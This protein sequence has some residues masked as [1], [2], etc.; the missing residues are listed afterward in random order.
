MPTKTSPDNAHALKTKTVCPHGRAMVRSP[1]RNV[2][3]AWSFSISDAIGR[4]AFAI[5]G[6]SHAVPGMRHPTMYCRPIM[7]MMPP[8]RKQV[9]QGI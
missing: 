5:S 4:L 2:G 6:A 8:K 3:H 7:K 9:M 1:K